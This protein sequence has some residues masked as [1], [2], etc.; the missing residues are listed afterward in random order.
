M[1]KELLE[2]LR[3]NFYYYNLTSY[4]NAFSLRLAFNFPKIEINNLKVQEFFSLP[5][6]PWLKKIDKID[7]KKNIRYFIIT[8]VKVSK[9][10][11]EEWFTAT[12]LNND[13]E[14]NDLNIFFWIYVC[15]WN[16]HSRKYYFMNKFRLSIF[17]QRSY[18]Y[19]YSPGPKL[20]TN[21]HDCLSLW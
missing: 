17:T 20:S 14:N 2:N 10:N 16:Y 6:F 21:F 18:R 19:L 4:R 8:I 3:K 1:K 13:L 15:T 9:E 12:I 5:L 11:Y 7:K